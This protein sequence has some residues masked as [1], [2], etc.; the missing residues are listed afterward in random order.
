M[1]KRLNYSD[2]E[3]SKEFKNLVNCKRETQADVSSAVATILSDV[4]ARGDVAVCESTAK[5]N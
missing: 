4:K 3:F 5:F 1:S 2:P